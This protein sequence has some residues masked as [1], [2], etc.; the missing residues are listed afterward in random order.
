MA[1]DNAIRDVFGIAPEAM[2]VLSGSTIANGEL[3]SHDTTVNAVKPWDGTDADR[4]VGWHF[5]DTVVGAGSAAGTGSQVFAKIKRGGFTFINLT[6]TGLNTTT[7]AL[8][9]GMRVF[10]TDKDSYSLVSTGNNP[11]GRV[12]AN[13]EGCTA[14]TKANVHMD[15]VYGTVS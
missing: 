6:V 7:P 15:N 11:V 9:F 12:A 10:A 1:V 4:L 13:R 2:I 14:T 8:N 5:G 3:C